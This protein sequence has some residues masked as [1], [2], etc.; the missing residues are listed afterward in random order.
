M[1]AEDRAPVGGIAARPA[2]RNTWRRSRRSIRTGSP[3]RHL[4]ARC[5]ALRNAHRRAARGPNS[6]RPRCACRSM[7]A[8]MRWCCARWKSPR[9]ALPDGGGMRAEAG[10]MAGAQRPRATA[11]SVRPLVKDWLPRGSCPPRHPLH[12]HRDLGAP[13]TPGFRQAFQAGL[14]ASAWSSIVIGLLGLLGLTVIVQLGH[15]ERPLP[16]GST[17]PPA[18][19]PRLAVVEAVRPTTFFFVRV[20]FDFSVSY[21][22]EV[23]PQVPVRHQLISSASS[24]RRCLPW[25]KCVPLGSTLLG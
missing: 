3:R 17:F 21:R 2:R 9:V 12:P 20:L 4:F 10:A 1:L 22:S 18:G 6:S 14:P 8:W 25:V 19:V 5:G 24:S 15:G 16:V 11:E 23:P 7:C 13:R